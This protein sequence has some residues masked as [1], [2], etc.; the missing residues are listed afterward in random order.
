MTEKDI[1]R[2]EQELERRGY[3]YVDECELLFSRRWE[4]SFAYQGKVYKGTGRF[5][6]TVWDYT[7]IRSYDRFKYQGS[8]VISIGGLIKSEFSIWYASPEEIEQKV[9]MFLD[10]ELP[11]PT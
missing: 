6:F 1:Y 9:Q 2:L 7:R 4:K 10:G 3:E 11:Q 8:A 5:S